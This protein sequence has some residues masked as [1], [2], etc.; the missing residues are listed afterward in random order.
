MEK[1]HG[2]V[3]RSMGSS[4]A[5]IIHSWLCDFGKVPQYSRPAFFVVVVAVCLFFLT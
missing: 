3:E 5:S 1:Q 2:I 4:L